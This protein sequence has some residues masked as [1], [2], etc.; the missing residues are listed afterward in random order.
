MTVSQHRLI[1]LTPNL[2]VWKISE[3]TRL[4]QY[5]LSLCISSQSW[6][7][8][9]LRIIPIQSSLEEAILYLSAAF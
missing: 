3:E 4:W 2:F 9:E 7:L 6:Y 8:R 5:L 1:Y